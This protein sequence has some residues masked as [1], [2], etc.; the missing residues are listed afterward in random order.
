MEPST[1]LGGCGTN[2]ISVASANKPTDSYKFCGQKEIVK[3]VTTYSSVLI[4][5]ATRT[6]QDLNFD[7]GL[8]YKILDPEPG[9]FKQEK[10][11]LKNEY[12]HLMFWF[13]VQT[14]PAPIVIDMTEEP[15]QSKVKKKL[16]K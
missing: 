13:L 7:F 12:S 8:I 14:T 9:N 4:G 3:L 2:F 5:F 10:K 1:R 6:F 11:F 16:L 15:R